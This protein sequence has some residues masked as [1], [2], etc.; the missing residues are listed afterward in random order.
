MTNG[1][2]GQ[3]HRESSVQDARYMVVNETEEVKSASGT[4]V[5]LRKV[6]K[7]DPEWLSDEFLKNIEQSESFIF[8][9]Q[10]NRAVK[11]TEYSVNKLV[12]KREQSEIKD[13]DKAAQVIADAIVEGTI[14]YPQWNEDV[15]HFVRRVNFA[16]RQAPHYQIPAIGEEEKAFIIQQAIFKCRS[17]KEV[18]KTQVWSSLKSW[19]SYEQTE[20]VNF[21]APEFIILP[22]KK[23]PVKLRYDEKGDV[24]LSETIQMLYDCPLPLTVAEGK[25][26]VIFELLAPSRRPV[27]ITRDLEQ[28]WKNSYHE[29]KK[30]LK[31]RYPKH[32]WR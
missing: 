16:S 25:V 21:I 32:E 30:E 11:I 20:A 26:Q 6:T 17:L 3:L 5:L 24:I 29:I 23:K 22:H 10:I 27:Q 14:D 31:G 9:N 8:D 12:L 4:Q 13:H 28:F 15:E 2:S 19:L 7:I 18:Q 1:R